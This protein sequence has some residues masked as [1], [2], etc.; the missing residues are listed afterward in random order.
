MSTCQSGPAIGLGIRYVGGI[1][2]G[3][4]VGAASVCTLGWETWAFTDP[5]VTKG[6]DR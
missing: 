6:G 5:Q 1:G 2:G 4:H 3:K